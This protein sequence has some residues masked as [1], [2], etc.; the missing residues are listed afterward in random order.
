MFSLW[1]CIY[2]ICCRI[3]S[4]CFDLCS[5][6]VCILPYT[7]PVCHNIP[8]YTPMYPTAEAGRSQNI[9]AICAHNL[10]CIG[11]P[12]VTLVH[13]RRWRWL[14]SFSKLNCSGSTCRLGACEPCRARALSSALVAVLFSRGQTTCASTRAAS[15]AGARCGAMLARKGGRTHSLI[16]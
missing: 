4:L 5:W 15:T 12:S 13:T 3:C 2:S 14:Y 10:V 8:R 11:S 9:V 6:Y 1:L 16:P 7:T